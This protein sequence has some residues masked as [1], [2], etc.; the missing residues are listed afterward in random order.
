MWNRNDLIPANEITDKVTSVTV[1]FAMRFGHYLGIDER[2]TDPRTN[3]PVIS[4][5]KLTTSQL[6]KF[7]G[8]VKKQQMQGYDPTAFILL[9]PKLAY[10]VGR[11]DRKSKIKDFYVV[12]SNAIDKVSDKKSFDNFIMIF[13]AIVAY[14]KAAEEQNL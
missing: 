2:T 14:H 3:R 9:K 10:A 12:I 13:E 7:F 1:N 4:E 8:E 6:R 5:T 11:A